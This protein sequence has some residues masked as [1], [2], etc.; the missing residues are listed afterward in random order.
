[1]GSKS[2]KGK[3]K[4]KVKNRRRG[5]KKSIKGRSVRSGKKK[6]IANDVEQDRIIEMLIDLI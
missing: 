2:N 6:R 4:A 5:K 1:M 3:G